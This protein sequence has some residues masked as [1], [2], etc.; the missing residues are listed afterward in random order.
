MLE[1]FEKYTPHKIILG[2]LS[3]NGYKTSGRNSEE[4]INKGKDRQL[5]G[6]TSMTPVMNIRYGSNK[7][8]TFD[9]MDSMEQKI[10]K[11]M[12]MDG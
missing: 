1:V 9:T 10:D 12:I 8:V 5:A 11:L 2:P 3:H 7:R 4:S 6:Q